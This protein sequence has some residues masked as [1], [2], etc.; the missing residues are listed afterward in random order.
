MI[1]D[2]FEP[3]E[4]CSLQ[5]PDIPKR[6]RLYNLKP[7]GLGT[8]YI[9]SLTS[10]ITRLAQAHCMPVG[11]LFQ[12]EIAPLLKINY[13]LNTHENYLDPI[14]L[15]QRYTQSLNGTGLT[16]HI[17]VNS[18][19]ALT[20]CQYLNSLTLLNFKEIFSSK[21]LLRN[22]KAWCPFCYDD[23]QAEGQIIYEPLIWVFTSVTVCQIHHQPLQTQCPHCQKE[24]NFIGAYS[25]LG[26]CTQCL[27]WLGI[28]L[29]AEGLNNEIFLDEP[30][31]WQSWVFSNIGELLA[32]SPCLSSPYSQNTIKEG[33]SVYINQVTAGNI[34]V[35]SKLI[36]INNTTLH[37][38]YIGERSPILS[39]LL[40][41]CFILEVP[42][43]S[44]LD[45]KASFIDA[46]KI[47]ERFNF[48]QKIKQYKL[49]KNLDDKKIEIL[50]IEAC[51]E[52]PP[53][54]LVKLQKRL[55]FK[56]KQLLIS[57]FPDLISIITKRHYT[58]CR[59]NTFSNIQEMLLQ[60]L[61]TDEYPPPTL[62]E[63]GRRI[64]INN[65]TLY[66]Y[67]PDLCRA[68]SAKY[69]TYR[70]ECAIKNDEKIKNT[71]RQAALKLHAEGIKPNISQIIK[72]LPKPGLMKNKKAIAV[73]KEIL[74]ELGYTK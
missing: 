2:D 13:V 55:G 15:C 12:S 11:I 48:K 29:Q 64:G 41:I 46:L 44:F 72:L 14:N 20:Q 59:K 28:S 21:N 33:F 34:S 68:I 26:Y 53:P 8:I 51:K 30:V 67:C 73:A 63:V 52:E 38:W 31:D 74:Y 54:S 65:T 39:T 18:L 47:K 5:L 4:L 56:N 17:V 45:G 24:I 36:G 66:K 3:I 40:E 61:N 71:V 70:K 69:R 1:F 23:W 50:L 42:L 49:N 9:E 57:L 6:S 22:Y 62:T 58:Y 19:K 43:V 27:G 35:F 32:I 7:L 25:R 60:S 16:S 10:Y 37:Y